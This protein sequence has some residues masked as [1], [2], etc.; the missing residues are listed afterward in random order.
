MF[1]GKLQLIGGLSLRQTRP[2]DGQ[3]LLAMF[4]AAR[5]WL[6]ETSNDPEFVRFLFEDQYRIARHGVGQVYPEHLDF[7]IERTGQAIGRLTLDFG[8]SDWRISIME[9]HPEARRKGNGS[10]VV[11]SLQRGAAGPKMALT[12]SALAFPPGALEFWMRQGFRVLASR[13]PH[14]E[15]IWCP[16]GRPW[17]QINPAA[18]AQA[19]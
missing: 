11:R 13:P 4:M 8:Y 12:G 10:D 5:P 9:I 6:A 16:P 1:A 18:A 15:I 19:G 2:E 3:F 7:V 17:P 14:V